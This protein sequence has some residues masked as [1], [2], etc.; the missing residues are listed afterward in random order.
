MTSEFNNEDSSS[1]SSSTI[2]SIETVSLINLDETGPLE[3]SEALEILEEACKSTAYLDGRFF[4]PDIKADSS[5]DSISAICQ[6]CPDK[7]IIKGPI[8]SSS[9]FISHLKVNYVLIYT[10]D[11]IA[12]K[13]PYDFLVHIKIS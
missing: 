2:E 3:N 12:S 4:K 8:R 6:L 10:I 11:S 9:N 7:K 1:T 13:T 5:K